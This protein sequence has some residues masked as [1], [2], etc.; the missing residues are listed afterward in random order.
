MKTIRL[1]GVPEHFNY[2]IHQAIKNDL[3][4]KAEI[5]LQWITYDGGTGDMTQALADDTC[6]VCILLTEGIISAILRDRASRIISG[7]VTSPLIWGVHTGKDQDT[8]YEDAFDKQI[9]ISRPGSG[10][11]LMPTVDALMKGKSIRPDQFEVIRNLDG[12]IESLNSGQSNIFYWEK[13]TT[14]PVVEQGLL[15]RIGEFTSPWPCFMI[16][17]SDRIIQEAPEALDLMLRIIH[18]AC[19]YFMNDSKSPGIIAE[20]FNLS[21]KDATFWFHATE[22]ATNSWVSDKTL[23]SVLFTLREAGIVDSEATQTSLVWHR[24]KSG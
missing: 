16:A 12:A 2:P 23:T 8:R 22:W 6:D 18:E 13:Y 19:E 4:N 24:G 5:D 11:H 17:A 21:L 20:K 3:F 14:K 1:G 9:A 10:S 7:Y 15:R